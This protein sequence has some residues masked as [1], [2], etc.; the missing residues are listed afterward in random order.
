MN[1]VITFMDQFLYVICRIRLIGYTCHHTVIYSQNNRINSFSVSISC[2]LQWDNK[3]NK[4][5]SPLY[6]IL[7]ERFPNK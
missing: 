5:L 4:S 3:I 2:G 1:N 6:F 7:Q